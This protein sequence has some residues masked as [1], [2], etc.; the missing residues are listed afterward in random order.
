MYYVCHRKNTDLEKR[1]GLLC[2]DF[3]RVLI[4]FNVFE[5][6]QDLA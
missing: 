2:T 6:V 4:L 1:G 3:I 5:F